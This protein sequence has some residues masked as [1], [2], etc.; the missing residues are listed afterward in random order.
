VSI[1][2]DGTS[3]ASRLL[4]VVLPLALA[5]GIAALCFRW[6]SQQDLPTPSLWGWAIWAEMAFLV[7]TAAH[8]GGH[9]LCGWLSDFRLMIFE[10]GPFAWRRREGQWRVAFDMRKVISAGGLC[11]MVPLHTRRLASRTMFLTAGG[12]LGSLAAAIVA[13]LFYFPA[14]DSAWRDAWPFFQVLLVV[15][16]SSVI[17]NLIPIP[18]AAGYSDGAR[19]RQ[20]GKPGWA[21]QY[22]ARSLAAM[23]LHTN[24]RPA[25]WNARLMERAARFDSGPRE[26]MPVVVLTYA[27]YTDRGDLPKAAQWMETLVSLAE[28]VPAAVEVKQYA[29]LIAFHK[30]HQLGD[31]AGARPWFERALQEDTADWHLAH[32]AIL[33]REGSLA[34]AKQSWELANRAAAR[35]PEAGLY[36]STRDQVANVGLEWF[37]APGLAQYAAAA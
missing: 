17:S 15:S 27:M 34:E 22:L 30:A 16:A 20:L 3:K 23:S 10:V 1:P 13:A 32:A 11:G 31:A 25:Q 19:M 37:G 33:H 28:A 35:A 24:E 36:E 14:A 26:R 2:G 9:W 8:E 5:A 4:A 29:A 12:P 7:S 21:D 6:A 18:S